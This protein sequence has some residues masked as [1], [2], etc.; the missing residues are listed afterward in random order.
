MNISNHIEKYFGKIS[1]GWHF[2]DE[3]NSPYQI[4]EC[5]NGLIPDVVSFCTLGLC[6]FD[7]I[8]RKSNKKIKHEIILSFDKDHIPKNAV[9]IVKQMAEE[10]VCSKNAYMENQIVKRPGFLFEETFFLD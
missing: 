9:A 3:E 1:R 4:V 5:R 10:A 8:S 7:F 2:T 6:K